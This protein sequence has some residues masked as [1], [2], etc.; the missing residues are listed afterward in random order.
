VS[1]TII[2][3][4]THVVA[5]DRAR[6]PVQPP[7]GLPRLNWFDEHPVDAPGLV[8]EMDG[9][10]V[11]GAVLVQAKGAYG[12]DNSY[13][14]DAR[15]VAP[16]RLV[17]ACIVDMQAPDRAARL[18]YWAVERGMLGIR[19]FNIPPAEPAWLDDPATAEVLRLASSLGVRVALCVLAQDLPLVGALAD[20]APEVPIALD[21][22]GFADLSGRDDAP[23]VAALFALAA[24]PNVSCKV[25]TTMLEPAL[26]AGGDPREVLE[27]L[28]Q[29]F[30][31]ERLMWG[32]DYP[33][34]HSEPYPDVVALARHACSRLSADEQAQFLGGTALRLWPELAPS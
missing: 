2:D 7:A 16:A 32:S 6:Y 28:C 15:S 21:H 10:G 25:T 9:A 23:D 27:R 8:R 4:H 17:N 26:H 11:H 20:L 29:V 33:Q 22:C 1:T 13:A 34:H 19:L 18:H 30:G 5:G 12:F 3:T 14:A 31:V 24:K